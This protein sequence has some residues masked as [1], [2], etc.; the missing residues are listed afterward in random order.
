M[1][2]LEQRHV[3][4]TA[5]RVQA[6]VF[7]LLLHAFVVI[8]AVQFVSELKP[9]PLPEPI[10]LEVSMVTA[11]HLA[12]DAEP[13][14]TPTTPLSQPTHAPPVPA[15][16]R[17]EPVVRK[18]QMRPVVT[19]QQRDRE[20]LVETVQPKPQAVQ[21]E[22]QPMVSQEIQSAQPVVNE[23][24]TVPAVHDAPAVNEVTPVAQPEAVMAEA[25]PVPTEPTVPIE[26]ATAMAVPAPV[27]QPVVEAKQAEPVV[28]ESAPTETRP[29]RTAPA[30]RADYGWLAESLWRR[31]VALKR[32]PHRARLNRWEGKV[33]LTAV[34]REDGHLGDL[35]VKE[36]SGYDVLDEDAME[37]VKQACPLHMKHPLGRPEVVVQIPINYTLR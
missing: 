25:S 19:A 17:R 8:A 35:R 13:V 2:G 24:T 18:L 16:V 32:Y 4:T 20:P 6:W 15:E 28:R 7:S 37:L 9:P 21:V 33:L 36:S 34:I 5:Y 1:T 26:T 29:V 12:P 22:S 23:V 10:L 31:V 27:T 11:P 30:A 3:S 14:E